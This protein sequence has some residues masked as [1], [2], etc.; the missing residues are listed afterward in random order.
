MS[1]G[2]KDIDKLKIHTQWY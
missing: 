2:M 1:Q